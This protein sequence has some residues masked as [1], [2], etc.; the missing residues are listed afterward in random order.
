MSPI[1]SN[2]SHL[3]QK[4]ADLQKISYGYLGDK[5]KNKGN[6]NGGE[7]MIFPNAAGNGFIQ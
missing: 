6:G 3:A 5:R 7:T 4:N 1:E 2:K